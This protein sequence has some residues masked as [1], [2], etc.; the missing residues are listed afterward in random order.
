MLQVLSHLGAF[1]SATDELQS[2]DA[3]L[4]TALATLLRLRKAL[5]SV[6]DPT[7]KTLL[8]KGLEVRA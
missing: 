6:T 8:I 4:D 1:Q 5:D 2:D 3:R 7:M